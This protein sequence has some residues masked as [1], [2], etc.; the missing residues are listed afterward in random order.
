MK[1]LFLSMVALVVATMSY[2]QNT[3][4]AT[5]SHGDEVTMFYGSSALVNAV[6]AAESGD[7][8]TLSSGTFE[9]CDISKGITIR[10]AGAEGEKATKITGYSL[11]ISIPQSDSNRFILEGVDYA[12][13]YMYI[14]GSS[15]N[16]YFIKCIF[17][18]GT[19]TCSSSSKT[20]FVN[21]KIPAMSLAGSHYS[22]LVNC[23]IS[24]FNNSETGTSKA[25]FYNC[26]YYTRSSGDKLY[27]TSWVNS[28][29][30]CINYTSTPSFG[31]YSSAMNCILIGASVGISVDCYR[32]KVSE[33]FASY[34]NSLID[35][36]YAAY[37]DLP[38]TNKL[39]AEAK[40]KYLGTDGKEV[41]LYGGQYPY[42][43][44]P[45]YPLITKL[46]VAKQATADNKLSVEIEVS[47]TE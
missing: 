32:P 15:S 24:K 39:S 19:V 18:S 40:T 28:I 14:Y 25:E 43:L 45:T 31:E 47:A 23:D 10:G 4:V 38:T 36:R 26:Y 33:V 17:E 46:N 21:C 29:I 2:A 3:L 9:K 27:K 13:S 30:C 20:T 12:G 5:L 22:K 34:E 44:T 1:K 11:T 6:D 41:G 37:A 8:I 42:D 7:V 35:G 16:L